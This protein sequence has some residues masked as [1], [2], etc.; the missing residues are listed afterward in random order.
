MIEIPSNETRKY[1]SGILNNGIKYTIIKDNN[2]NNCYV[3]CIVGVGSYNDPKEY[4]GLAH[5]LEHMLF[6]G[7]KKYPEESYFDNIIKLNGG[8]SNAY[9]TLFE[10]NYYYMV[11]SHFLEQSLDIFSRFFIDPLFDKNSVMRE[12]NAVDSEHKKNIN[13]DFWLYRQVILNIMNI[14][15]FSTGNL[16]TLNKPDIREKMIEFY[17]KYY[18]SNNMCITILVPDSYNFSKNN[19]QNYFINT[20]DKIPNK[21]FT[22]ILRK[23]N[24]IKNNFIKNINKESQLIPVNN[25]KELNILY[26]WNI[27]ID[28]KYKINKNIRIVS[29]VIESNYKDNLEKVLINKSLITSLDSYYLDDGIFVLN[30]NVPINNLDKVNI[31][32]NII[33]VYFDNLKK[34]KWDKLL[35]YYN[36][37]FNIIY[38]YGNKESSENLILSISENM[39]YFN[40]SNYYNGDKII[41]K[42]DLSNLK[43]LVNNLSFD[44]CYIL[45]VHYNDLGITNKNIDPYYNAI[46]G[47]VKLYN[48]INNNINFDILYYNEFYNIKPKL[49]KNL[50]KYNLPQLYSNR[51]WYGG[52]SKYNEYTV[53][54]ILSFYNYYYFNSIENYILTIISVNIINYYLSLNFHDIS[55]IGYIAR[56][57]SNY[58]LG[59]I[60]LSI[61][62]LNDKYNI[63]FNKVIEYIKNILKKIKINIIKLNLDNYIESIQNIIKINPWNLVEHIIDNNTFKYSYN[64]NDIINYIKKN[65]KNNYFENKIYNHIKKIVRFEKMGL[66]SIFYGN[67]NIFDLP[68]MDSFNNNYNIRLPKNPS[69]NIS[70]NIIVTHPNNNEKNNLIMFR[71]KV[72]TF[73]PLKIIKLYIISLLIDNKA[74]SYLRTQEQLGYL[75]NA[76]IYKDTENYYLMIKVQSDK[77]VDY[78]KKIINQFINYFNN[79]LKLLSDEEYNSIIN[80]VKENLNYKYPNTKELFNKY[81]IEIITSEY[82]FNRE[83]LLLNQLKNVNKNNIFDFYNNIIKNKNEIIINGQ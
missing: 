9:T 83:I 47:N 20:F 39:L 77:N 3:S 67:I 26:F 21:K 13:N 31:I 65:N 38:E 55:E 56:F 68:N 12:I 29:E 62:G 43:K 25:G 63:F 45:Y 30:L 32:N 57:N 52:V 59:T 40:K 69:L 16:E 4:S 24:F 18:C 66:K 36:R 49:I 75:V 82:T 61:N 33:R 2:I 34:L 10:T 64:Y 23:N 46:Y 17:D 35:D 78:V 41:I 51:K 74:Y 72:G 60:I 14:K 48:N 27:G 22:P 53:Y 5:F 58:K 71:Y 44:K 70:N 19:F 50:D 28:K 79:Y 11:N 6:L 81:L 80:T 42:K 73:E 1:T 7:S 15:R 8:Y 54:G 76:G 37:K